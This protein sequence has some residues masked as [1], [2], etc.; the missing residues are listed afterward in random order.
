M[1][2][3]FICDRRLAAIVAVLLL[4]A[5]TWGGQRKGKEKNQPKNDEKFESGVRLPDEQVLDRNMSEMLGA[6]QVGDANKLHTY[7]ADDVTIVSGAFEPP[8][9]GWA[10]YLAAYE[11]QRQRLGALRLDRRNTLIRV[12]GDTAWA[13]YQWEFE[14]VVDGKPTNARGQTT[15][16]FVKRGDRWLIVHNHTSEICEPPAPAPPAEP[17][18]G[19]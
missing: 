15:L 2:R 4:G 16:V 14:A 6:W 1:S 11:R 10:N 9:A 13:S 8:I 18:P 7:Y 17:K 12:Q 5:A 19:N 3:G